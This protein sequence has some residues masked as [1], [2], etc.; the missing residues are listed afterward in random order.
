[1][2]NDIDYIRA[3][4]AMILLVGIITIK[5]IMLAKPISTIDIKVL[6]QTSDNYSQELDINEQAK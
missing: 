4:I 2:S 3:G 1:M 5:I 6:T